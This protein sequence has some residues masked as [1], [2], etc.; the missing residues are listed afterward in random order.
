MRVCCNRIRSALA[1]SP[2][3]SYGMHAGG[4]HA[5]IASAGM[6]LVF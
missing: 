2:D 5:R 6:K 3:A 4:K 1:A